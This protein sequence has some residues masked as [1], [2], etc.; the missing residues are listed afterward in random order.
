M[1]KEKLGLLKAQLPKRYAKMIKERTGKSYSS[2]FKTF[3]KD[4]TLL[5]VEVVDAA[6]AILEE[7]KAKN[8]ERQ[9]KMQ[10]LC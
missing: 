7:Q 1:D 5:V 8:E 3:Q 6:L 10:D 9:K 4:S 2:I